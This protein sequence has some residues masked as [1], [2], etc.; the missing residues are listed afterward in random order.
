MSGA[1]LPFAS[2]P[3]RASGRLPPDTRLSRRTKPAASSQA[4]R[5]TLVVAARSPPE[6]SQLQIASPDATGT[7]RQTDG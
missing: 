3:P 7:R 1:A 5:D 4:H 2:A 6:K